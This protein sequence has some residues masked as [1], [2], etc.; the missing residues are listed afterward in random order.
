MS[1]TLGIDPIRVS[2]WQRRAVTKLLNSLRGFVVD[3][4]NTTRPPPTGRVCFRHLVHASSTRRIGGPRVVGDG[5]GQEDWGRQLDGIAGNRGKR[6][7][8]PT[9]R[10]GGREMGTGWERKERVAVANRDGGDTDQ[11]GS[12]C[13]VEFGTLSMASESGSSVGAAKID[14]GLRKMA[15]Q[16]MI[17]RLAHGHWSLCSG[18]AS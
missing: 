12:G 16:G 1:L 2:V 3:L 15:K 18:Q 10:M 14:I 9:G 4:Q 11:L 7:L 6:L 13:G 17:R 5:T 8:S